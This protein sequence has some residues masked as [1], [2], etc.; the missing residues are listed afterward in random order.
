MKKLLTFIFL[1]ECFVNVQGQN[2]ATGKL[3]AHAENESMA[4]TIDT[5]SKITFEVYGTSFTM[6]RVD[7]GTFLMGATKEQAKSVNADEKPAHQV[8]LSTFYIG[9]TT[10]TQEL[11]ETVMGSNPSKYAGYDKPVDKVS[12]EDCQVFLKELNKIVGKQFRLPT[13]AEWEFAARGGIKSRG[14]KYS[15]SNKIKD[16]AW[17]D[18]NTWLAKSKTED[19]H[20]GLGS[21]DVK[22]KQPNELGIYDMSGNIWEWCQD[23]YGMYDG[24]AQTNPGGVSTGKQKVRRGGSWFNDGR[25]ARVSM[26]AGS[27]PDKRDESIGFRLA[28]SN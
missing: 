4:T 9:E 7:G 11:W 5:T 26:R 25:G 17:I 2:L 22:T 13:E 8:T 18:S 24:N 14:Y 3:E 28:L 12:W 1:M 16:V 23:W 19:G 21:R 10:V 6:I 27:A 15:G 20:S